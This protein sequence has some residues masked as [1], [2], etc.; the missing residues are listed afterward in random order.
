[1]TR[2]GLGAAPLGG[3]YEP[4]SESQAR[5]TVDLAYEL[6]LRLFDTAPLYGSGL[7]EQ[8]LGAA[9]RARPRDEF[10]ISTKVGRLL[11][12][13][14]PSEPTMFKGAPPLHPVFDFSYDGA[15][16]SLDESLGRLGLDRVDVVF[17]HD[18]D[19]HYDEALS[20]AYPALE[21]LRGE[22][23]IGAI[24]VGMNQAE[25]LTRF[26]LE[27][28]FDCFL[29][30]GRYTLLDTSGLD[31]L[32]PLCAER[33]ISVVAGGVFNSGVL[34]SG[35]TYDYEPAE[36]DILQ[37]AQRL[38]EVCAR[39]DVPLEAAALQFPLGHPAVSCVVVG[40]R[41]PAEVEEDG[42]LFE[43][44]IPVGLWDELKAERLIPGEAPTPAQA[45]R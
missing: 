23:V 20:G 11:R 2:L 19:D 26:A 42:R 4:V 30:A 29:L 12:P 8:R 34:A 24:G 31:E 14:G 22:G 36:S 28:D 6:G 18:P 10:V 37:R 9:L 45:S 39:W 40:C 43:L 13:S 17:I 15:L 41:A 38:R 27:G 33:G 7:S 16:R 3:L 21:R 1:V 44:D 35:T 5:A 32:L 25:L